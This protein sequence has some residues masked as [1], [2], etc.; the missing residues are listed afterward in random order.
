M[1][2]ASKEFNSQDL[3][4]SSGMSLKDFNSQEISRVKKF[5]SHDLANISPAL[6]DFKNFN[7]QDLANVSPALKDSNSQALDSQDLANN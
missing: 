4:N 5:N 6:K 3:P 7:S 1:S 2:A